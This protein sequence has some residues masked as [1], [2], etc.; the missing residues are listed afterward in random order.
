MQKTSKMLIRKK[1]TPTQ[2]PISENSINGHYYTPCFN[3]GYFV[4]HGLYTK[5]LQNNLDL[6]II[7]I[8]KGGWVLAKGQRNVS[9]KIQCVGSF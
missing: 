7:F 1:E 3:Q 5:L 6:Q 2:L 8:F 4:L 9:G